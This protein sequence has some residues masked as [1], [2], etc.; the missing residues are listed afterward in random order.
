LKARAIETAP[1]IRPA[2]QMIT[3]KVYKERII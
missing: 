2:H 1:R 3:Y